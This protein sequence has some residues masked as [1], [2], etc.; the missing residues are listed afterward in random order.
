MNYKFY[1]KG[2]IYKRNVSRDKLKLLEGLYKGLR[3]DYEITFPDGA[4]LQCKFINPNS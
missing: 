1:S 2:S 4:V 3:K